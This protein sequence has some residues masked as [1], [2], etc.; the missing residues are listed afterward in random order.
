MKTYKKLLFIFLFKSPFVVFLF[1]GLLKVAFATTYYIDA[2]TGNDSNDGISQSTTWKTI[3]KV[4]NSTFQPGDS[5]LFKRGEIWRGQLLVPSSGISGNPIIF[6]DYGSGNLPR[7]TSTQVISG[8]PETFD[9]YGDYTN[10]NADFE[11]WTGSYPPGWWGTANGGSLVSKE[12]SLVYHGLASAKL[13]KNGNGLINL[14]GGMSYIPGMRYIVKFYAK[15]ALGGEQ[16]AVKKEHYSNGTME[17][18]DAVDNENFHNVWVATTTSLSQK[19]ILTDSWQEY[20]YKFQFDGSATTSFSRIF[21]EVNTINSTAYIDYVRAYPYWTPHPVYQNVY[22]IHW[23][24]NNS[25]LILRNSV[26]KLNSLINKTVGDLSDHEYLHPG[27]N[28]PTTLFWLRDDSG[29]PSN[30]GVFL[31]MADKGYAINTNGRNY[32]AF[33]DLEVYGSNVGNS[34]DTSP[35]MVENSHDVTIKN[36][37]VYFGVV[38]ALSAQNSYNVNFLNNETFFAGSWCLDAS[39][40]SYDV[41]MYGNNVHDCGNVKQDDV[42]GHGIGVNSAN[43]ITIENNNIHANGRGGGDGGTYLRSAL[44]IYNSSNIIIRNNHV[45]DNFRGGINLSAGDF[46][47]TSNVQVYGNIISN[48]ELG[49]TINYPYTQS[50]AISFSNFKGTIRNHKIF[51]NTVFGN[52]TNQG[53][54]DQSTIKIMAD[55]D[56]NVSG[57]TIKNNIILNNKGTYDLAKKSIGNGIMSSTIIDRNIYYRQNGTNNFYLNGVAENW[58]SYSINEPGSLYENIPLINISG[59]YSNTA[60]FAPK[61]ESTAIDYGDSMGVNTDYFGNPLYGKPDIGAIEYQPPYSIGTDKIDIAGNIRIYADGKF[62]NKNQPSG[63]TADL[64]ITPQSGFG[65]GNYDEWMDVTITNWDKTSN[66]VKKWKE[67]SDILGNSKITHTIGDLQPNKAYAIWYTKASSTKIKLDT[68]QADGNGRLIF[69]YDK[70]YSEIEFELEE[71]LTFVYSSSQSSAVS[72]NS[73]GSGGG[74]ISVIINPGISVPINIATTTATST[75]TS[76]ASSNTASSTASSTTDIQHSM[77]NI[78]GIQTNQT[79]FFVKPLKL[80]SEGQDVKNLQQILN[81]LGFA[82]AQS[83]PGSLGNETNHF[84]PLTIKAVKKFQCQHNIVCFGNEQTTGWGV[85]GPKTIAKLNEL[86]SLSNNVIAGGTANS[87]TATSSTSSVSNI[88]ISSTSDVEDKV[89]GASGD[90][91]QTKIIN[92]KQQIIQLMM[93]AIE[94]MKNR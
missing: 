61:G 58:N 66:Y 94:L 47:E 20:V 3:S 60:D 30:S 43:N 56:S 62:R 6:G 68:K 10:K 48:N 2:T 27:T 79:L 75:T 33:E 54:Q 93:Q 44:T 70:G 14:Y 40:N 64:T 78:P 24:G 41:V 90:I 83:G 35:F 22:G 73:G 88:L 45:H 9:L 72:N 84:G 71:D 15:G 50:S 12:T 53:E 16:I 38:Y 86:A 19:Y 36:S 31:E 82:I 39:E 4:N 92:I 51:N 5:I 81:N 1:L 65:S 76:T 46:G 85:V 11:D 21:F 13:Y 57:V 18:T 69:D 23:T 77:S 32:L 37:K 55:I 7:I 8:S 87:Q 59:L 91:N 67:S 80:K 52:N 26:E 49:E 42:D 89:S 74:H 25:N 17:L 29:S 28:F 63:N 34:F